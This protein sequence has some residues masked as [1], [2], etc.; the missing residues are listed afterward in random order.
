MTL[1]IEIAHPSI[2]ISEDRKSATLGEVKTN[3]SY[4]LSNFTF[5]PAVLNLQRVVSGRHY[6]QVEVRGNG[7]WAVAVCRYLFPEMQWLP[8]PQMMDAS[9]SSSVWSNKVQAD[10]HFSGLR[11]GEGL[12]WVTVLISILNTDTFR[13]EFRAYVFFFF[14]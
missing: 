8:R 12:I 11:V 1:N 14:F 2:S 6:W 5:L 9:K 13:E 10:W 3:F 7:Q 4:N